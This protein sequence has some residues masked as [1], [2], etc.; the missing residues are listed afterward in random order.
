M[1]VLEVG[2]LIGDTIKRLRQANGLTQ[3]QLAGAAGLSLSLIA[4]LEQGTADDPKLSTAKAI[5]RVL[6][7]GLDELA[8]DAPPPEKPKRRGKKR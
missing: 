6:G 5:A 8:A 2:E 1:P 7:V 4:A 3:Q